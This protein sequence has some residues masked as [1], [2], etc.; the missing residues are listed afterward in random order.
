MNLLLEAGA[1]VNACANLPEDDDDFYD[2]PPLSFACENAHPEVVAA[3]L[4]HNADVN[5]R[6]TEN[7]TPLEL[8]AGSE[9]A[10]EEALVVVVRQ[11]IQA[12]APLDSFDDE[13][14]SPLMRAAMAGHVQIIR[15]LLAAGA[16]P[17][18]FKASNGETPLYVACSEG[19]SACVEELAIHSSQLNVRKIP[20]N[21]TALYVACSKGHLEVVKTL[22]KAGVDT[23]ERQNTVPRTGED[24]P[25]HSHGCIVALKL[26]VLHTGYYPLYIAASNGHADIVE[27]LHMAGCSISTLTT[28]KDTPLIIAGDRPTI[29]FARAL[30]TATTDSVHCNSI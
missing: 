8:A 15:E 9:N 21:E 19:H 18:W 1:D 14:E 16:D 3:L 23:S 27:E 28:N 11:L 22:I 6:S 24:R 2:Q 29:S 13:E 12:G 10:P 20:T 30:S 26:N 4:R 5:K 17:D 7:R 25:R